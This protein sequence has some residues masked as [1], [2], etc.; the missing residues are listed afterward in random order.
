[1]R[2]V[3]VK[4]LIKKAKKNK[5]IYL[6]TSDL[7]YRAFE[8]FKR[9]FPNRFINVG[10]A[11]NNMLGI[12]AGLALS[13]KKVFVYSILSFLVF[14]SFEQIRNNI[15]HNNLDVKL[16]GAGGG[17]SYGYQGIS[18]NTS[19]DISILKSLPNLNV[20]SPGSETEVKLIMTEMFENSEPCFARL[21]K[22]P[23]QDFYKKKTILKKSEG[24]IIKKGKDIT[25]FT[26]GN[27]LENVFEMTTLLEK[28]N[29]DVSLIS[30]PIIKPLNEKF[31]LKNIKSKFVICIEENSEVNSLGYFIANIIIKNKLNNINFKNFALKDIVHNKIGTQKYLRDINNLSVEKLYTK[32]KLFLKNGK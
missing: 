10:V 15:C 9:L 30:C 25:I 22:C 31:V 5:N 27:I 12:G 19:E 17:F 24:L 26:T 20:F 8:D 28:N 23:E 32:V 21:G 29:F 16:I 11:E 3:F 13:G 7:G 1:M 18:H 2:F 6:L 14:R 4:E